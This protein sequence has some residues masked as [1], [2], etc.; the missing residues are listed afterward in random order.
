[1]DQAFVSIIE[2]T[3]VLDVV[4]IEDFVS[5]FLKYEKSMQTN[6]VK[7]KIKVGNNKYLVSSYIST[8]KLRSDFSK[9]TS[10]PYQ[11]GII[12]N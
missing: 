1:M 10:L 6:F 11:N 9:V 4:E 2:S 5:S 8:A 3:K 12:L 7:V